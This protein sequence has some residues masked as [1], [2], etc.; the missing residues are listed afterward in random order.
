MMGEQSR[1]SYFAHKV[2]PISIKEE[3]EMLLKRLKAYSIKNKEPL[4]DIM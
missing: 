2:Q 4:N 3:S 1:T